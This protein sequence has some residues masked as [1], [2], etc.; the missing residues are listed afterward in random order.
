MIERFDLFPDLGPQAKL[1]KLEPGIFLEVIRQEQPGEN[2]EESPFVYGDI[3]PAD[4]AWQVFS[5][6][7]ERNDLVWKEM[8]ELLSIHG[9]VETHRELDLA[10][11]A[12]MLDTGETV[13]C[14]VNDFA[15]AQEAAGDLPGLSGNT[16]LWVSG[17]DLRDYD[18]AGVCAAR[19]GFRPE[20]V[21]LDR[22]LKAWK[23][24]NCRALSVQ[25]EV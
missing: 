11:L 6:V 8:E 23:K 7:S 14:L 10:G 15:L 4:T 5:E 9:I 2:V 1:E 20:R 18:S 16:L 12:D 22:F 19:L 21:P 3:D 17:L 13:F 24:G 25:M